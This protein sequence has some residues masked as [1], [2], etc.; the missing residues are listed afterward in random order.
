MATAPNTASL[1]PD[2]RTALA[3]SHAAQAQALLTKGTIMAVIAAVLDVLVA[4]GL[5]VNT[6]VIL[7]ASGLIVSGVLTLWQAARHHHLISQDLLKQV[8]RD[9]ENARLLGVAQD[10]LSALV[11][12]SQGQPPSNVLTWIPPMPG[13]PGGQ[14]PASPPKEG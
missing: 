7:S 5:H 1:S 12:V 4:L 13:A 11:K 14:A 8:A 10:L 2:P 9:A 6:T 3:A